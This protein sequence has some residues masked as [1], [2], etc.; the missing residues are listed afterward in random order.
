MAN[1][2]NPMPNPAPLF[3][4][5]NP[6]VNLFGNP[7]VNPAGAG[8]NQPKITNIQKIYN[9]IIYEKFI[10]EFKRMLRKYP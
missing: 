5:P 10:N 7:I 1:P 3:G 6:G 2:F 4:M 9:C 8:G